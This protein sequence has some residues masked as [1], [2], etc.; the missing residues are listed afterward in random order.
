MG[1]KR[2]RITKDS[3][4]KLLVFLNAL[5]VQLLN[6]PSYD[7]VYGLADSNGLTIY[8][9]EY[10]DLAIGEN[11]P[12]ASLDKALR[13]AA[14][15]RGVAL[16]EVLRDAAQSAAPGAVRGPCKRKSCVI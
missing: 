14:I 1:V 3:G 12:M 8:D 13:N 5:N 6:P 10:L 11:V 4:Q 2:Q 9:A 16:F 7:I 15:Q